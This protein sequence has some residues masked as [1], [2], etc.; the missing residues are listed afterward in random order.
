MGLEQ[1][2]AQI[3]RNLREKRFA[4]EQAVSQ[5]VVLP[6]LGEMSWDVF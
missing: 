1:R 2:L 5:G 6:I 4:N 3:T